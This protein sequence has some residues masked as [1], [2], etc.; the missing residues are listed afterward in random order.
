MT[1]L[2]QRQVK[3]LEGGSKPD[4]L[5]TRSDKIDSLII[6][7]RRVDMI[8]PMLTQLTYE[9]LIDETLGIKN[10][11][12]ELPASL[13]T[14][15][16]PQADA[17]APPSL[18]TSSASVLSKE[19]KKKHH[20]TAAND[21]LFLELRDLNFSAVGMRL[22]KTARRLEE[23]YKGNL[24][25]KT[26]AQLRDFV[27]KLGG[28]Q[29]QQQSLRIHIGVTEMI[30]PS[31]RTEVFNKS[32]EIQQSRRSITLTVHGIVTHASRNWLRLAVELRYVGADRRH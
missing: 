2:L 19:T 22:N 23:D 17:A 21:V 15:A 29:S 7:D 9:G 3:E 14:P 30:T 20:L 24:K 25:A 6:L 13:L 8:T 26:V 31:T 12:V 16:K 4:K 32:L 11:Y 5:L 10:S 1:G 18:A 27:G 28:L